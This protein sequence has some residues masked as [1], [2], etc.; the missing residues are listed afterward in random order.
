MLNA[1]SA[2]WLLAGSKLSTPTT[3]G[4]NPCRTAVRCGGKTALPA[5]E[6]ADVRFVAG[7]EKNQA[8]F[9]A[10][11]AHIILLSAPLVVLAR[12]LAPRISTAYGKALE[13]LWRLADDIQTVE[14]LLQRMADHEIQTTI[15]LREAVT[16]RR[17]SPAREPDRR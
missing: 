2:N 10:Q 11:L 17:R 5:T 4:L 13:D 12:R 8:Q 14:P 6:H 3:G 1:S 16:A 7:C 9:H 15:P